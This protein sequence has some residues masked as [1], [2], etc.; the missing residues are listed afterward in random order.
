MAEAHG[1]TREWSERTPADLTSLLVE[2]GRTVRGLSFYREGEPACLDLLSRIW[3]AFRSELS[4]AGPLELWIDDAGFHA[5]GIRETVPLHHIEDLAAA[6]ARHGVSRVRLS[7]ELTRESLQAFVE[8]LSRPAAPIRQ[9]GGLALALAHRS[10]L[11][12]VLGGG[13]DEAL[14][15][16][17]RLA[18]TP[19]IPTPSLG[20]ALLARSHRLVL[21]PR[22]AGQKPGIDERPLEAPATD[23]RGERLIFRLIELDRC[24]DDG[25][26]EFLGRRIVDW[27]IELADAG[28]GDECHRAILVLADHAVGAGGR[29]GLQARVA[30]RLCTALASGARLQALIDRA[31]SRETRARVRATQ[32]LLQLGDHAIPA[33]FDRIARSASSETAAQLTATLIALGD[34][35]VGH[36]ARVMGQR[37]DARS[38]LAIRLAG[39]LQHPDLAKPL[40]TALAGE[41]APLRREAARA[42]AH[43]GGDVAMHALV[44]A[45]TSERDD[46]PDI[47]VHW[48]GVLRDPRVVQPLL[49][50]LERA[51]RAGD[52]SRARDVIRALGA[53]GSER[54]TPRLVALLERRSLLRRR[55]LRELQLAALA[56]L[57]GLPGREARRAIDRARRHRDAAVRDH[58]TRLIATASQT[59]RTATA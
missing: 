53:L 39:E 20:A 48:L 36:L 46:L 21:E 57:A 14:A 4:R 28:L 11:G 12:I 54:A 35:A 3:L 6:L 25:A 43:L 59:P 9:E 31:Q 13:E 1:H 50:V 40:A 44:D 17:P 33:L 32:V 41:R 37:D 58:A 5:A 42:L 52:V 2:L 55:A 34:A 16:P 47:A 27:A 56:A 38:L 19:A 22:N 49:A 8:L 26:Y 45:L 24:T 7:T 23:P 29:S 15:P 30:Q 18:D 10:S 51:T